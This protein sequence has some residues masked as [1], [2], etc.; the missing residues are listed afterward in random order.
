MKINRHLSM[1]TPTLQA[2]L[3]ASEVMTKNPLMLP[4]I[5]RYRN[6]TDCINAVYMMNNMFL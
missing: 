1:Y 3:T 2:L 4:V 6:I 5:I